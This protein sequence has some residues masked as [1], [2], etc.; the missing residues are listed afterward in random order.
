MKQTPAKQDKP[1]LAGFKAA[2]AEGRARA[3]RRDGGAVPLGNTGT[4]T[5]EGGTSSTVAPMIFKAMC[6]LSNHATDTLWIGPGE[7]VFERLSHLYLASGGDEGCLSA[8]WPEYF[9]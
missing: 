9:A 1:T 7:T 5:V 8:K 4:T 2:G 6:D 3:A